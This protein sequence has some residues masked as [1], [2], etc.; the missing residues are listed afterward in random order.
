MRVNWRGNSVHVDNLCS[1][2]CPFSSSI[3]LCLCL[4]AIAVK[5]CRGPKDLGDAGSEASQE[6]PKKATEDT[7]KSALHGLPFSM[8]YVSQNPFANC[9]RCSNCVQASSD[10]CLLFSTFLFFLLSR[11]QSQ[12]GQWDTLSQVQGQVHLACYL[13][14]VASFFPF[15]SFFSACAK[16]TESCRV[17]LALCC[18]TA[19]QL[20]SI[21]HY[22]LCGFARFCKLFNQKRKKKQ[23]KR[24]STSSLNNSKSCWQQQ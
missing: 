12:L 2:F 3:S 15:S 20:G 13:L 10:I 4:C 6:K 7:L 1:S 18:Q 21:I 23:Q 11:R 19:K 9:M 17:V 5:E 24:S 22:R 14:V 8:S 16:S